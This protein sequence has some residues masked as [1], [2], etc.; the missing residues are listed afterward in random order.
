MGKV[1]EVRRYNS[2]ILSLVDQRSQISVML[3]SSRTTGIMVGQSPKSTQTHLQY[4]DLQMDVEEGE[5]VVTSGMG[6]VFPKGILV[7]TIFKVEKKNYGLFHDLYVE[8]TVNFSTLENVYVIKKVPDQE[9][10]MLA[11]EEDEN[12]GETK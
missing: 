3:E 12:N 5:R 2:R 1:V 9:I 4:I 8:P 11:N 10:I 6:G 7:G